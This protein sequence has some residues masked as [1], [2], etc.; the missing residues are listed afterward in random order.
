M[1][2]IFKNNYKKLS[3][4]TFALTSSAVGT[5][6]LIQH[7]NEILKK[8]E[9][10]FSP[11][12][13]NVEE[14]LKLISDKLRSKKAIDYLEHNF[15]NILKKEEKEELINNLDNTALC[16]LALAKSKIIYNHKVVIKSL[17][18]YNE[19][20]NDKK[21]NDEY[22][23]TFFYKRL[24]TIFKEK[25]KLFEDFWIY[26]YKLCE[27]YDSQ[28]IEEGRFKKYYTK[29][30]GSIVPLMR[31][32]MA[33]ETGDCRR[34]VSKELMNLLFLI[35]I[36]NREDLVNGNQPKSRKVCQ[37]IVKI[38]SN[39]AK[40]DKKSADFIVNSEWFSLLCK[41]LTQPISD[42]EIY[43][44]K[45]IFHNILFSYNYE[46]S[47]IPCDIIEIFS[48]P[49]GIEP[50]VDIVFVHGIQGSGLTT[51]RSHD[52]LKN[53][54]TK[55]WPADWLLPEINIP[56]RGLATDYLSS[57]FFQKERSNTVLSLAKNLEKQFSEAGIGKRPTIFISHSLGG[58]LLKKILLD[59]PS[60]RENT[61]SILF[62]AVPHRGSTFSKLF[63]SLPKFS[64]EVKFL[65]PE[66]EGIL[67]IHKDFLNVSEE[68]PIFMSLTENIKH[69]IL[70]MYHMVSPE[71]A[72]FEK[73]SFY[74]ID[75]NHI[76]I[77]KPKN[78]EDLVYILIKKFITDSLRN[79]KS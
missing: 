75:I 3:L 20:I 42:E 6:H 70:K 8:E 34:F 11:D 57:F 49:N 41:M 43:W 63:G 52:S 17:E 40:N 25:S 62:I 72:Y 59:N 69:D 18:Q 45:K 27:D 79:L 44:A 37:L 22:E 1:F 2:N 73:G 21:L 31:G 7:K 55:C 67:K 71:S 48:P 51:W 36:H 16:L 74:H 35:Y 68:I 65:K 12:I 76:D 24:N 13:L 4:L 30:S 15:F 64:N 58:I 28:C 47:P 38:L 10:N 46:T 78:K 14:V 33:T 23:D 9:S 54:K 60:I 29:N 66:S 32:L 61:L 26:S 56:I 50:I 39:I 19:I 77:T 5:L 53:N